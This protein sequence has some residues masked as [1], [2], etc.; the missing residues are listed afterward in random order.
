[1]RA[2]T[3]HTSCES[4]SGELCAVT[5]YIQLEFE[6]LLGKVAFCDSYIFIKYG[7]R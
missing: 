6:Q 1:M 2:K 7:K 4:L 5:L 3:R